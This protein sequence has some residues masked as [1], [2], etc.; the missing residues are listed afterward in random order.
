MECKLLGTFYSSKP[1]SYLWSSVSC[2]NTTLDYHCQSLYLSL[3]H[4]NSKY[5]NFISFYLSFCSLIIFSSLA[6]LLVLGWFA[7]GA[8]YLEHVFTFI[9]LTLHTH[10]LSHC[11]CAGMSCISAGLYA[12]LLTFLLLILFVLP[13][14]LYIYTSVSFDCLWIDLDGIN[15]NILNLRFYLIMINSLYVIN[16]LSL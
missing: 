16:S 3:P 10:I 7:M 5:L 12:S 2:Q 11:P 9:C 4:L 6:G 14:T 13:P 1:E 15:G 8:H